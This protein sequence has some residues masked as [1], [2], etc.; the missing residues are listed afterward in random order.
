MSRL[1]VWD[2]WAKTL[3]SNVDAAAAAAAAVGKEIPMSRL[4][5]L[6]SQARQKSQNIGNLPITKF[7]SL[8]H[9]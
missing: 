2:M 9:I 6:L 5:R 1:A 8:L 3:T 7:A 4:P